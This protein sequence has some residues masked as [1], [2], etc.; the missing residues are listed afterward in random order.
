MEEKIKQ[1]E[2]KVQMLL[3][4]EEIK[5]VKAKY[6]RCIDTKDWKG[7]RE[8]ISEDLKTSY[9]NGTL[10]FNSAAE[11]IDYLSTNM[12][13]ELLSQH[14]C[15]TPEIWFESETTA[16]G[17]WYLHDYLLATG[18]NSRYNGTAIYTD[19]YEKRNGKWLITETGYL[20][21]FAES[22]PSPEN[23]IQENMHAE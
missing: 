12:P 20:R 21:I 4:F 23:K 10:S 14:N 9:G 2:K 19:K 18:N 22:W 5:Q 7:F 11:T 15:H 17:H 6:L 13:R 16:H 3:D 1:L 8:T